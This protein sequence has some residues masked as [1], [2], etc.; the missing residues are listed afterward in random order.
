MSRECRSCVALTSWSFHDIL[1]ICVNIVRE[2]NRINKPGLFIASRVPLK[3]VEYVEFN[4]D[5]R[6][7][8][9]RGYIKART[10]DEQL[11]ICTHLSGQVD[12][13]Y[14]EGCSGGNTYPS[15]LL[16]SFA[17]EQPTETQLVLKVLEGVASGRTG[18]FRGRGNDAHF[19]RCATKRGFNLG[20]GEQNEA[21][22]SGEASWCQVLAG[23]MNLVTIVQ[24]LGE[25][26]VSRPLSLV[27]D[28]ASS[29]LDNR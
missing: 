7:L 13:T 18:E 27:Q 8:T 3:S 1:T 2:D 28:R 26:L 12:S 14:G 17:K 24:A 11:F 10:Q 5:R 9:E 21:R 29:S 16:H 19:A 22:R 15:T 6:V 4:P 23:R 25:D 20:F